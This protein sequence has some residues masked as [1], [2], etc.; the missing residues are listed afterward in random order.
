MKRIIS[1][2]LAVLTL[3]SVLTVHA[4]AD[5]SPFSDV[6]VDRWSFASVVFAYE[7]GLMNGVGGGKFSP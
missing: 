7:H 6:S 4:L 1:V 5:T 2:I 3:S